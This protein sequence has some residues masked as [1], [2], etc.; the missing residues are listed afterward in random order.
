M[1]CNYVFP[2][3][4]TFTLCRTVLSFKLNFY[5]TV[6]CEA[7]ERQIKESSSENFEKE[8]EELKLQCKKLKVVAFTS[9]FSIEYLL[10]F[11]IIYPYISQEEQRSFHDLADKMMEEKDKEISRLL[12][13]IENLRQL[14][15]SRPSVRPSTQTI[16]LPYKSNLIFSQASICLYILYIIVTSAPDSINL[17]SVIL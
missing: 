5:F 1:Y 2:L 3:Q 17:N 12:D 9:M 8:L 13:D 7:L 16:Y 15:D 6:R 11:L 10:L 14:L 4:F